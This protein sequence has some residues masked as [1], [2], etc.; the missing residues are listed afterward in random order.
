MTKKTRRW[1]P[2]QKEKAHVLQVVGLHVSSTH[3]W[4]PAG[5]K[6]DGRP[7]IGGRRGGA[8]V[9][10]SVDEQRRH[11]CPDQHDAGPRYRTL[12]VAFF[13]E[14]HDVH[15]HPGSDTD[16]C[17]GCQNPGGH[18]PQ[19]AAVFPLL[20]GGGGLVS[21][22]ATPREGGGENEREDSAHKNFL[23]A[24]SIPA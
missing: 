13:L 8:V 10:Y 11:D 24:E 17:R 19:G 21:S 1:I 9:R 3:G 12:A 4:L 5:G 6:A 23:S 7:M 16:G 18:P 15:T 22:C 2:F 20:T 14:G